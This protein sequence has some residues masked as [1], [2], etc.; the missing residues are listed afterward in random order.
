[1]YKDFYRSRSGD[2]VRVH[3]TRLSRKRAEELLSSPE[4]EAAIQPYIEESIR[5]TYAFVKNKVIATTNMNYAQAIIFAYDHMAHAFKDH[6]GCEI[7]GLDEN[8]ELNSSA[9]AAT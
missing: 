5:E 4:S 7:A 9:A 1:M 3:T 6:N 2:G 8:S